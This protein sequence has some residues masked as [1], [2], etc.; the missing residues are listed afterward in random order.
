MVKVGLVRGSKNRVRRLNQGP[1]KERTDKA[2]HHSW[3]KPITAIFNSNTRQHS[4]FAIAVL[5]RPV[6]DV[7][8]CIAS[9]DAANSLQ[10]SC[11]IE[12][13]LAFDISGPIGNRS[14]HKMSL[15]TEE[16]FTQ[17]TA[18]VAKMVI[19]IGPN[20]LVEPDGSIALQALKNLAR[21]VTGLMRRGS[22][23][24]IVP[25]GTVKFGSTQLKLSP[26]MISICEDSGTGPLLA[27]YIE[28]YG[29][30]KIGGSQVKITSADFKDQRRKDL[31][32][33]ILHRL[34]KISFV[35]IL[36][37]TN[38]SRNLWH[39]PGEPSISK[40]HALAIEIAR[41]TQAD[42]LI[43]LND[44]ACPTDAF[45]GHSSMLSQDLNQTSVI[46]PGR[47]VHCSS[48]PMHGFQMS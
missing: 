5:C 39:K 48:P 43:V 46:H 1:S 21:S 2:K 15:P 20:V 32:H 14:V 29:K 26:R 27:L 12:E 8:G 35:P 36:H 9:H 7:T 19:E 11:A 13:S 40:E 18:R 45:L 17:A 10:H 23:V 44:L 3:P 24:L 42:L 31:L 16:S 41:L 4:Y 6:Q 30:R 38:A 37:G 33:N 47:T 22:Q 34:L 25:S 28:V